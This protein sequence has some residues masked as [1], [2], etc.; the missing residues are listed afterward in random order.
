MHAFRKKK[1]IWY[2]KDASFTCRI[3]LFLRSCCHILMNIL[4]WK[5]ICYLGMMLPHLLIKPIFS[6]LTKRVSIIQ[7]CLSDAYFLVLIEANQQQEMKGL[8]GQL[9][10]HALPLNIT[11]SPCFQQYLIFMGSLITQIVS[12]NLLSSYARLLSTS[13][14]PLF[15]SPCL[16]LPCVSPQSTPF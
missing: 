16:P 4:R 3:I 10:C 5:I 11:L 2:L 15:P 14:T 13:S 12:Q 1:H 9:R 8:F 6:L 7:T